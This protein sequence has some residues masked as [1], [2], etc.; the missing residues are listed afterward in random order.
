MAKPPNIYLTMEERR[1]IKIALATFNRQLKAVQGHAG[2]MASNSDSI[3]MD[4]L[5]DSAADERSRVSSLMKKL[6]REPAC[7]ACKGT[8]RMS[9]LKRA[10]NICA[11]SGVRAAY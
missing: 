11:G 4:D 8:G 6:N 5:A 10:C 1:L 9:A 3:Q 2:L 7:R